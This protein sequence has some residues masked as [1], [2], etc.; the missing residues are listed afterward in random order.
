MRIE[1][2]SMNR[3]LKFITA[4][5]ALSAITVFT[6]P[7][8]SAAEAITL[9]VQ[10]DS[11]IQPAFKIVADEFEK[12]NP[13][14]KV[15]LQV[16]DAQTQTTTNLQIMTS[17][18]APDVASAPMNLPPYAAMMKAK[19]FIPIDDVWKEANLKARYGDGVSSTLVAP[20]G[21]NYQVLLGAVY[22]GF[23]WINKDAFAKAKIK[24]PA[25]HQI[26]SMANFITM[27]KKLRAAG[28]EPMSVGG[29]SGYHLT[30]MLDSFLASGVPEK[31]LSNLRTNFVSDVPVTTSYTDASV[32]K[33]FSQLKQV[34][35]AK[36]F[37]TGVLGQD[38]NVGMALFAAGRAAMMMGHNAT[39]GGLKDRLRVNLNLDFLFLPPT[40]P[41]LK[42]LP[43][44]SGSNTYQIPVK[45]KHPDLAKKFLVLLMS[46]EMQLEYVKSG[47]GLSAVKLPKAAVEK[48]YSTLDPA[49]L[50][51]IRYANE[52]GSSPGWAE[53][54]PA[55]LNGVT[56]PMIQKLF[57]GKKNVKQIGTELDA[58][59]D[60]IRSE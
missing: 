52:F 11:Y 25:D 45:A 27:G 60:K 22:Y 40:T 50:K 18:S 13:G 14:V 23:A 43:N 7:S 46:D 4:T 15:E 51:L 36:I 10:T 42:V 47:A 21:K 26:G 32:G 34:Y 28:Y 29:S 2:E 20:D 31:K 54:V 19:Q 41:G 6:L 3:N 39:P 58:I 56:D 33:A 53:G 44:L 17:D 5:I 12:Q 1:G 9:I 38:Q 48:A 24:I 8:S 16:L 59:R 49:V 30:W 35:D 37:Q 57:L 55:G